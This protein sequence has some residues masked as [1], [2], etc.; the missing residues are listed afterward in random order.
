MIP[1]LVVISS[2][3][4][5]EVREIHLH[6]SYFVLSPLAFLFLQTRNFTSAAC[7]TVP[8]IIIKLLK[9]RT[10]SGSHRGLERLLDKVLCGEKTQNHQRKLQLLL[11]LQHK[12]CVP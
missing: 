6:L 2:C 7:E 8:T 3:F 1:S 9:D 4:C 10:I 12:V 5:E 11:G